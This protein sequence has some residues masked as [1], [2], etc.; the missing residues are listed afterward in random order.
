MERLDF[1]F[2]RRQIT[3]SYGVV[4]AGYVVGTIAKWL[5]LRVATAAQADSGASSK[6][7]RFALR[8]HDFKVAFHADIAVAVDSDFCRGHSIS[9][10]QVAARCKS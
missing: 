10:P 3:G 8:V 1:R 7:E 4:E 5:V 6:S 2:W 9:G